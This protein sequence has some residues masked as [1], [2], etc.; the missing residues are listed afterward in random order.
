M[1]KIWWNF[2]KWCLSD[3]RIFAEGLSLTK[4][5][6]V[7]IFGSFFGTIYEEVLYTIEHL[8]YD[9][10]ILFTLRQ[11]LIYGPIN[12][13]Y[14]WGAI[15]MVYVLVK[16]AKNNVFLG[17]L[18][19]A[20]IGGILEYGA[21]FLQE[22]FTG[23]ISWDYSGYPLN[24]DGRTTVLYVLFWGLLAVLLAYVIYPFLSKY[25]EK[26][27]YNIGM[28]ITKISIVILLIDCFLSWGALIR[29]GLRANAM[30]AI[31][32]LGNFFDKFY[33]DNFLQARF[34]NMR[35]R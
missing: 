8:I 24:I 15:I 12:P 10:S 5:Y 25:I 20:L 9:G 30:E 1:K 7:F 19:G 31:T 13:L 35:F 14:G 4:L 2:K 33:P 21:S 22:A 11:G 26:I 28:L 23:Q 6:W 29:A 3:K 16:Y 34:P 18:Y 17:Y 32:P 27:P